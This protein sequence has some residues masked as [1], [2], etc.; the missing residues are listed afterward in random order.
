MRRSIERSFQVAKNII[1]WDD[2]ST[3]ESFQESARAVDPNPQITKK[4]G[5]VIVTSQDGQR[6]LH[7]MVSP[8]AKS[9]V[10]E[11]ERVNE[12]RDKNTLWYYCRACVDFD[13]ML[14]MDGDEMYSLSAL[15]NLHH[16]I[17]QAKAHNARVLV[18]PFIYVWN[19]EN[20][21]RVDAVYGDE[22]DG[23]KRLRF[24]RAFQVDHMDAEQL[25]VNVFQVNGGVAGFHCGS[26]P[27]ENY[28]VDEPEQGAFM[29][30][31]PIVHFGYIDD[32][33]RHQKFAFYNKIDPQNQEEGGYKHL[34]GETNE[35]APDGVQ[36]APWQDV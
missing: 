6:V 7:W 16:N 15:R 17:E 25:F 11:S 5:V 22:V 26:I 35:W 33:L 19:D 20:Q 4:A 14:C 27:L 18:F 10:R 2:G 12:I 32:A 34:I 23:H 24:P 1:V 21:Q 9:V 8:F 3:D 29:A 30:D 31:C 28:F 36:T 13:W